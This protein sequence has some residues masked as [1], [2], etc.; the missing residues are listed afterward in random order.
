[1]QEEANRKHRR[2]ARQRK[3][4]PPDQDRA[5]PG[6]GL[7]HLFD[8]G[9]GA[10]SH[11]PQ[12]P[13]VVRTVQQAQGAPWKPASNYPRLSPTDAGSGFLQ[14]RKTLRNA[15]RSLLDVEDIVAVGI[16]PGRASG[17]TAARGF[18]APLAGRREG[19]RLATDRSPVSS[20]GTCRRPSTRSASTS[21][22]RISR[23]NRTPAIAATCSLYTITIRN[24][25]SRACAAG[26]AR[27]GSSGRDSNGKG[28]RKCAAKAWSAS[29][30]ISRPGQ[31][32]RSSSGAVLETPVGAIRG[33]SYQMIER[34]GE[35]FGAPIA[36]SAS[37]LARAF[38]AVRPNTH[39]PL[40]DR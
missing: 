3:L 26:H 33:A 5:P 6:S 29:S 1:M 32:F 31:G 7:K 4:W 37:P 30:R 2:R 11:P 27:T 39:G 24:E 38:A 28:C 17:G 23:S 25:G 16:D 10:F 22:P 36:A 20:T 13:E 14:R 21:T 8:G 12:G 34:R 18:R 19:A 15:L 35:E 9:P 40:R